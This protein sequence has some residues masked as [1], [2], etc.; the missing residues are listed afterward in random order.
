MREKVK[1]VI[2]YFR[3]L[4]FEGLTYSQMANS[5]S[6]SKQGETQ[7]TKPAA[8]QIGTKI[9]DRDG[10]AGI[11]RKVTEWNGSRWYDVRFQGGEGVR[12]DADIARVA[13]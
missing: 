8:L 4:R 12:Y 13:S 9:T 5:L 6:L 10:F 2:N 3:R 11:V 7:M 1:G